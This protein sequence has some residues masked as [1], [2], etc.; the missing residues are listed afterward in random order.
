MLGNN[1]QLNIVD[2]LFDGDV[3]H[4]LEINSRMCSTLLTAQSVSQTAEQV[5]HIFSV[6]ISG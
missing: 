3:Q 4:S 1:I 2:N 6:E 5:T